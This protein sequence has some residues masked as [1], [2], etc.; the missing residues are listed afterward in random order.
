MRCVASCL[1]K[2]TLLSTSDVF[3][4]ILTTVFNQFI[5]FI[6]YT[7]L[8][9]ENLVCVCVFSWL[10]Y[11]K[12]GFSGNSAVLETEGR[13]TP[14]FQNSP[15]ARVKSLRPLKRVHVTHSFTSRTHTSHHITLTHAI[16]L[17]QINLLMDICDHVSVCKHYYWWTQE[18]Q[19][20]ICVS[21]SVFFSSITDT[22][23]IEGDETSRPKGN[24]AH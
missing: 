6:L 11:D 10:V 16:Y 17:T 14:I 4:R 9:F 20:N 13:V 15:V 21:S 12:P 18:F 5:Q 24:I 23:W 19:D 8:S 2:L 22:G 3:F 1:L 7:Y